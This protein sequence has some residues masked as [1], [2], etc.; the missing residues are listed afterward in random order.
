MCVILIH[1]KSI[2]NVIDEIKVDVRCNRMDINCIG[3]A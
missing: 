1:Y 2:I 3:L